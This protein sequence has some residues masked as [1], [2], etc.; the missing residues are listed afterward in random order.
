MN[1][2]RPPALVEKLLAKVLREDLIEEILGDLEEKYFAVAESQSV[3]LAKLTYWYQALNYLKP[4]AI[5]KSKSKYSTQFQMFKHYIKISWRTLLRQKVFS[6][7]EIGGFAIGIAACL[8]I[9]LYIK[10]Q[11]GYDQHY[12][13]K[14]RIFRMVNQWSEG[15]ETGYWTNMHGPLKPVLEEGIP[16]M[17]KVARVVFW[18]WGDAGQ[19]YVRANGSKYNIYENGFFYAD[20]E[21][22]EILEIPMIYGSQKE[23]LSTPNS[24]VISQ[25][26]A[27][28]YFPNQNP[29]GKQ[30]VLNDSRESTFTVGGVMQEMN[31]SSHFQ[32]DFIMTLFGRK[33]GPGTSGWCCT[34]YN[35]Y[36]KLTAGADK[37][38][39]EE[40]TALIRNTY[41]LDKL[42][43]DGQAGID[44]MKKYQSYYL[45]PV[46]NIYLNQEKVG[47]ELKHGS[48]ELVWIFGAIAIIVLLI[49]CINF[50]NLAT[51]KSLKRA[52]EVGLRKAIGSFRSSLIAQYL[53]E[54][55]FY[56]LLA[57]I[58]SVILA[59]SALPLFNQLAGTSLVMPW[60]SWWYLPV[61]LLSV[62]VIGLLSGIYPALYLSGFKPIEALKG[63]VNSGG[64][65]SFLRSGMVIF[66]FT[67]TIVLIIGAMVTHQQFQFT[68]NKS[69]GY[70]KSQVI[71]VMGLNTMDKQ[72]RDAFKD[73]LVKLSMI[74]S[75]TLSDYFPV[76]DAS[77]Q[78]RN[79]WL[80][81]NRQS[82]S[83]FEAARWSVD[84]DYLKTLK[85]ELLKGRDFDKAL[86]EDNSIIVNEEMVKALRLDDPL[87]KQ[88]ID[89]FDERRTIVGVVKDFHFES[90]AGDIRPL[91]L[92]KGNRAA[93]LSLKVQS[94]DMDE[95][96]AAITAIWNRFK[97]DQLIEYSFLD[98]R[99]ERMYDGLQKAK[100]I[101]LLFAVLS[102]L[103]AC[104]GLFALS[105][106]MVEQRGKEISIRKVL[107]ASV[108]SVFA[109]LTFDF[110]KLVLIAI[111]LAVP[112][113][114]VFMEYLLEEMVNR[115]E[116][117]WPVF[118]FAGIL[119]IVIAIVTISFESLKAALVNPA[120]KLRSE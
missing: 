110:V 83:G 16:E 109:L 7:I 36:V 12:V 89:M 62:I 25:S 4:F 21:L 95:T 53:S 37:I 114:W 17:E 74:E 43:E 87:G 46:T 44:E 108:N 86:A 52:R 8:L 20:P 64:K 33:K 118:A 66:Q 54:S 104:L 98:Q 19:N 107:G 6:A 55:C 65:T 79:Y 77:V 96:I 72:K 120:R 26:K 40:K 38:A 73:E 69:L 13:Q 50:I 51:A 112:L 10:H 106:Y 11:T 63:K 31:S 23:A 92:V 115:V 45:Q 30:L 27:E 94:D 48:P 97:A 49:A 67:A 80:A 71:N 29:V 47:D 61:L 113:G 3:S 84:E 75:A 60:L 24:I 35:Y 14:D 18:S 9:T 34:N 59:W 105:V 28:K 68:M 58:L 39:V 93:T 32:G 88:L 56:S 101:F 22:L 5:R 42:K 103:V 91:A 57:V 85:I 102:I 82:E 116:L 2:N 15:G 111:V 78:N 100:T 117:S 70:E 1:R 119:A 99:F 81:E 90:L 76:A 41:V